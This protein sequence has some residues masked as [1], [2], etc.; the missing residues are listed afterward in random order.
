MRTAKAVSVD[1]RMAEGVGVGLEPVTRNAEEERPEA[2]CEGDE[3][4]R[5]W[6][7][8]R[9]FLRSLFVLKTRSASEAWRWGGGC[10][11]VVGGRALLGPRS[12]GHTSHEA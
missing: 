11:G 3:G 8:E 5:W 6:S 4:Q 9:A 10:G 7:A 12:M 2:Y 1:G